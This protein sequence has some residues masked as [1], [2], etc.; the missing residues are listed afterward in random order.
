LEQAK[1][2]GHDLGRI[3]SVA[4]FFV[5]RMDTEVDR[6][7]DAIGT[8]AARSLRGQ[9]AIANARL[10]Y[11]VFEGLFATDR[12]QALAAAG[13]RPQRPLWASTSVKNRQYRDTRYI[14]ELVAP[15]TVTTMPE[16]TLLAVADHARIT[17]DTIS[18][19]I[20]QA[21]EVFARLAEVGVDLTDV[22]RVLEDKGI[23][24]FEKSWLELLDTV[25]E[26]LVKAHD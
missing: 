4:S 21:R 6:R 26:Q 3:A 2:N 15:G 8:D 7:L 10:A 12:W 17:G 14:D 23:G 9:A 18:G 1:A 19:T 13:A 11:G 16:T 5:S 25:A 22:F 24:T 20:T